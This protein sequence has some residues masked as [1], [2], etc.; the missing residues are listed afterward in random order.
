MKFFKEKKPK[1]LVC[2]PHADRKNYAIEKWITQVKNLTYPKHLYGIY[3]CDNSATK[4]NVK[5]FKRHGIEAGYVRPKQKSNIAY[6]AESHEKCRQRAVAGQYNYMLHLETDIEVPPNIIE[7]LIAH[8]KPIT[9]ACYPIDMGEKSKLLF[10]FCEQNV[11]GMAN[12]VN[13]DHG[14]MLFIDGTLKQVFHAGIGCILIKRSV[15]KQFTFR[16]QSGIQVHPDTLFAY[17]MFQKQ[18]PIHVDTSIILKHNNS[19][20]INF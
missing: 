5:M 14:D 6:M 1:I 9:S 11:S 4:D 12:T 8:K 13:A 17:D 15:L 2:A 18:I 19:E 10:Q 3:V 16:Y 20:W 7:L